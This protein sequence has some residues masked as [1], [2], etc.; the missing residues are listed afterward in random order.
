MVINQVPLLLSTLGF[1]VFCCYGGMLTEFSL[2]DF[3]ESSIK[4]RVTE[5][6]DSDWLG[7]DL[8]LE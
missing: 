3:L 1:F 4:E 8:E 7:F 5:Y 2:M 6:V